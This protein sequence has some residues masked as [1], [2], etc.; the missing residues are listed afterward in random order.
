MRAFRRPG[1]VSDLAPHTEF[2]A[3]KVACLSAGP[4]VDCAGEGAGPL[5]ETSGCKGPGC[6]GTDVTTDEIYQ[7]YLR[8]G[9]Q[10]DPPPRSTR[11][12]RRRAATVRLPTGHPLANDLPRSS[13]ARRRRRLQEGVAFHRRAPARRLDQVA[14]AAERRPDGGLRNELRQ[15]RRAATSG[16]AAEW[17][18]RELR[19]VEPK[20]VVVMGDDALEF[21]NSTGFHSRRL[22]AARLGKLQQVLARPSRDLSSPTSTCRSTSGRRRPC[23][24]TRSRRSGS[25]GPALSAFLACS[26]A[27]RLVR[28]G[29]IW[30]QAVLWLGSRSS[31]CVLLPA[32]F[33]L[34][35]IGLPLWSS[36]RWLLPAGIFVCSQLAILL[37]LV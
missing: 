2:A 29:R 30:S 13:P 37:E 17:L 21:L 3:A 24:G 11:S 31:R 8:Q 10:G 9:D 15:V 7:R 12:R 4:Q 19:I 23:S 27:R 34:V 25:G 32:V 6:V 16:V 18:R 20:L 33:P 5:G 22:L 36:S 35:R 28:G 14:A 1:G 26:R